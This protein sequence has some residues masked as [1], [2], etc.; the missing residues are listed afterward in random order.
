MRIQADTAFM[1]SYTSIFAEYLRTDFPT[2]IFK[3]IFFFLTVLPRE[4]EEQRHFEQRHLIFRTT[5]WSLSSPPLLFSMVSEFFF[6]T[7]SSRE[8]G[9]LNSASTVIT[10]VKSLI[11][12]HC[13]A[14]QAQNKWGGTVEQSAGQKDKHR[15]E[16]TSSAEIHVREKTH[17]STGQSWKRSQTT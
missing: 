7:S 1:V 17:P 3:K 6:F 12:S 11:K 15:H 5:C 14:L 2:G 8:S 16:R 13:A 10:A 9:S 4:K